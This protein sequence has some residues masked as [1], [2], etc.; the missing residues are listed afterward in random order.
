MGAVAE[1][2]IVSL[3]LPRSMTFEEAKRLFEGIHSTAERFGVAIVGGD[4]SRHDGALMVSVTVSGLIPAKFK[5]PKGWTMSGA[6]ADDLL[7]VTG[8]LGGSIM[9][10][11][12]SFV[13]P[14]SV[15]EA[16][17]TRVSVNAATDISD[18]LAVDLAHVIRKSNVG[19]ELDLE[20]IPVS[21]AARTMSQSSRQ[22]PVEHA[23]YDGEDFELLLS[24][25]PGQ[26][27]SCLLYTSPSPRD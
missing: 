5:S 19:A 11:H 15:A 21:K 16:I 3:V 25:S 26:F 9:G 4:T 22:T 17:Q 8:P 20:Q 27:E 13:P 18:S 1:T 12:L 2:A 10:R 24:I 7:V 6:Q 23:L 14:L